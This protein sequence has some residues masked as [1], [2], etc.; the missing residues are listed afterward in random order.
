[1]AYDN[2]Q[3][4]TPLPTGKNGNETRKAS[5]FLPRYFRTVANEKFIS[6]TLDQL[7]S[8][9]TVEKVNGYIGRRNAKAFNSTDSYIN[10]I[11]NLRQDYQLEPAVVVDAPSLDSRSA[12]ALYHIW[13]QVPPPS[14]ETKTLTFI[15]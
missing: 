15:K 14:S 3:N 4:E 7:I 8:S 1:M 10:D 5:K 13:F 11:S 12:P 2:S 6:S 9:G